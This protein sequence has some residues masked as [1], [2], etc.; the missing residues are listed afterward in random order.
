[1]RPGALTI[2][3]EILGPRLEQ[4]AFNGRIV[5]ILQRWQDFYDLQ[6][7]CQQISF[8]NQF[9][10]GQIGTEFSIGQLE[11][12]FDCA[13]KTARGALTN[14]LD[15]PKLRGRHNLLPEDNEA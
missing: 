7:R 1:L 8:V 10:L 11:T 9:A 15:A 4:L 3:F 13:R 2:P 14:G 6:F 12:A 5:L